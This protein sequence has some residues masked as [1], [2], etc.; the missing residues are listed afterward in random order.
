MACSVATLQQ[1]P[2]YSLPPF[3]PFSSPPS[4]SSSLPPFFP[5]LQMELMHA[6]HPSVLRE[7]WEQDLT[8]GLHS[9]HTARQGHFGAREV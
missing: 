9:A 1:M 8:F 7:G 2:S 4:S 6:S 5:L 3:L